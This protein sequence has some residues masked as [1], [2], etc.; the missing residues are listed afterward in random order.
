MAIACGLALGGAATLCAREWLRR[1]SPETKDTRRLGLRGTHIRAG[2]FVLF[3]R[4]PAR[5]PSEAAPMLPPVVLVHGLVVSSRMVEPLA[6]AL[7][8]SGLQ[9]LAPDLPGFGESTKP[10]RPLDLPELADALAL[11]LR[12]SGVPRAI[13]VGASFGCHVIIELALR[14]P[15]MAERLVLLGPG[16]EPVARSLPL[17]LWRQLV[18]DQREPRSLGRISRVD[19][20]KAGLRCAAA[21][22][23]LALRERI[24]DKLPLVSVP[25]LVLRGNRDVIAP[26]GWTERVASLLPQ[27][28]LAV[29]EGAHVVSYGAPEPAAA[30][31]LAFLRETAEPLAEAA[32][33]R[34]G[35]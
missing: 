18:N 31:I 5:P 35:R 27:G 28:R 20:A 8:R 19:Y 23:R 12:A 30:A 3:T 2:P 26:Q 17:A 13:F 24:E 9:V 1:A 11:W 14:H 16:P 15:V 34:S 7:T 25:S 6:G 32:E 21:T 4:A 22:I 10:P 29:V 33:G